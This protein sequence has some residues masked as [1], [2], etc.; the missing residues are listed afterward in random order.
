[1]RMDAR[2]ATKVVV[3]PTKPRSA[4]T[5]TT[6][7]TATRRDGCRDTVSEAWG[8][9]AAA[10]RPILQCFLRQLAS[11]PAPRCARPSPGR[12]SGRGGLLC[13]SACQGVWPLA[14]PRFAHPIP[15]SRRRNRVG[16]NQRF[17]RLFL[18]CPLHTSQCANRSAVC[19]GKINHY[20]ELMSK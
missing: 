18:V 3:K 16:L 17:L 13:H 14:A 5:Q 10:E 11:L 7:F 2:R 1:M 19:S 9:G 20:A 6:H 15:E 8:A 4:T 12:L